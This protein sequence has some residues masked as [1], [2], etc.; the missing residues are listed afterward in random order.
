MITA[1][2]YSAYTRF[3]TM[4]NETTSRTKIEGKE[5][6][7]EHCEAVEAA[8]CNL[9]LKIGR[10]SALHTYTDRCAALAPDYTPLKSHTQ[11]TCVENTVVLVFISVIAHF[12]SCCFFFFSRIFATLCV[13]YIGP[14]VSFVKRCKVRE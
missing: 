1:A 8:S 7:H 10:L 11:A 9:S 6:Q 12:F 13:A 14:F 5:Q 4:H 3:A 2:S